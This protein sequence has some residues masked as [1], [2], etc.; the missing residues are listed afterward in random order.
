[1]VLATVAAIT[2]T[3]LWTMMFGCLTYVTIKG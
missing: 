2:V 1:M 3:S